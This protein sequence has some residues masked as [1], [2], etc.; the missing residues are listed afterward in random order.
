LTDSFHGVVFSILMETPFVAFKRIGGPSMFS[1]IETLLGL[2]GLG[3]RESNFI[4]KA[5]EVFE[6]DFTEA[7]RIISRERNKAKE[8]LENNLKESR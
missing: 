6:V 2:V 8:Y 4:Q 3:E 5:K 7:K 1:R